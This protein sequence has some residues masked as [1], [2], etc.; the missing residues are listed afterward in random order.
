[1]WGNHTLKV[2]GDLRSNR[3]LLDQV[4]HPRGAL[5]IPRQPD[6]AQHRY[7]GDKRLREF[8]RLIH[9][10]RAECDRD[11]GLVSDTIHRGGTHKA[12]YTYVHDKWQMRPDVTL[13]LGLRHELYIPLV[14]YTPVGGQATYDPDTNTIRVA[15][16]GDV[17]RE[18]W[19]EDP[20]EELQSAHR[21]IVASQRHQRDPR[22]IRRERSGAAKLLGP[23]LP[24]PA[25]SA[26]HARP[27]ALR[28]RPPIWRLA[29]P[30]PALRRFQRAASSTPRRCV[31]KALGR[32]TRTGPRERCT[33]STSR[34]SALCPA[35]SRRRLRMSATVATISS[36]P[37]T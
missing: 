9:A 10:G 37:T 21:H 5:P 6:R 19:R 25:G 15:G 32:S 16:Y 23:G 24:D 35:D 36:L 22:R 17:P 14:G 34:I 7:R 11:E 31:Q 1:M 8:A 13:D 30:L 26:V 29:C 2:G 28:R 27:T 4:N 18:P 12:V 20:V 33:R 3:H